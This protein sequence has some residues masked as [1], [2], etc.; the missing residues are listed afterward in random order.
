MFRMYFAQMR[1]FGFHNDCS[2]ITGISS[3]LG[4]IFVGDRPMY[5]IHIPF[6]N[7]PVNTA[8]ADAFAAMI[9]RTESNPSRGRLFVFTNGGA[10]ATAK[11]EA[12]YLRRALGSPATTLYTIGSQ[13]LGMYGIEAKSVAVMLRHD[14]NGLK[15]EYKHIPEPAEWRAGG[16]P[17]VG[18]YKPVAVGIQWTATIEP[19]PNNF[20]Y[21]IPKAD[22]L[23]GG[24]HPLN[25]RECCKIE[26]VK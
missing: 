6:G 8:A 4:A 15:M 12:M 17:S 5:A 21:L 2:G 7:D 11:T 22:Q 16:K 20:E 14:I 1:H 23:N 18:V 3:C 9:R 26:T 10:R 19:P 24:W 25:D 13:H